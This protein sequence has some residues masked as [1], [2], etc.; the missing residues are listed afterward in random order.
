MP[1]PER[2]AEPILGNTDG[3]KLFQGLLSAVAAIA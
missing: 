1:H 2:A 3:L